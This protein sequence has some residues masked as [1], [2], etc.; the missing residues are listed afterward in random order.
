MTLIGD[1]RPDMGSCNLNIIH[2]FAASLLPASSDRARLGVPQRG[3]SVIITGSSIHLRT[4]P[5][6]QC[7]SVASFG[8]CV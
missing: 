3:G 1:T 7:S 6:N 4:V 5:R 2:G 8:D